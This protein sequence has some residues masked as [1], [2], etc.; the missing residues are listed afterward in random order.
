MSR[1]HVRAARVAWSNGRTGSGLVHR[2]VHD[3]VFPD[4]HAQGRLPDRLYAGRCVI[5]PGHAVLRSIRLAV[6]QD[7]PVENHHGRL[8]ARFAHL[9]PAIRRFDSLCESGVGSLLGEK[10]GQRRIGPGRLRISYVRRPVEQVQRLRQG[11]RLSDQAGDLVQVGGPS[12]R[13]EIARQDR[14][15]GAERCVGGEK[16]SRRA[17]GQWLSR[18]G[19]QDQDQFRHDIAGVVRHVDLRN[20]GLRTDRGISR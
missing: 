12:C 8:P 6:R 13:R 16:R 11:K 10:H 9:F 1:G 4:H 5:A 18:T 7:R 19:R 14:R 17:Q 3:A 20:H 2:P 15:P